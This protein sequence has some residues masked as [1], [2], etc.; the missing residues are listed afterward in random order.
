MN[1]ELAR[2]RDGSSFSVELMSHVLDHDL[3][4]ARSRAK[5]HVRQ[6]IPVKEAPWDKSDILF[7]SR[8]ERF[9]YSLRLHRAVYEL[10]QRHRLSD[11]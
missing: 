7:M 8:R 6:L 5:A 3:T 10:V 9:A 11:E 4:G 2:E 1:P